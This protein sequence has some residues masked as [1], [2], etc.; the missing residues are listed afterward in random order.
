MQ[1]PAKFKGYMKTDTTKKIEKLV[2]EAYPMPEHIQRIAN[3]A[4]MDLYFGPYSADNLDDDEERDLYKSF[5]QALDEIKTWANDLP[6]TLYVDLDYDSVSESEPEGYTDDSGEYIE[7]YLENTWKL[8]GKD[9]LK[10]L[11]N[12]ELVSYL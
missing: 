1:L 12:A 2:T 5:S 9:I 6:A 8:E 3:I 10:A 4:T 11:F 7:P